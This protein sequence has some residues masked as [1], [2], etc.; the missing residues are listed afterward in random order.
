MA[1]IETTTQPIG[2]EPRRWSDPVR[3]GDLI[4]EIRAEIER[5]SGN[6]ACQGRIQV[7]AHHPFRKAG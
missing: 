7:S 5:R 6:A 2:G 1:G 4:A 3:I